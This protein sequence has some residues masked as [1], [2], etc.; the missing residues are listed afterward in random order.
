MANT[1]CACKSHNHALA[2]YVVHYIY[3]RSRCMEKS[4][5]D[6]DASRP[7]TAS[8]VNT[9]FY[10]NQMHIP[11]AYGTTDGVIIYS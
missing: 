5:A 4:V 6:N 1:K 8:R 3:K 9:I 11:S 2:A 7:S 10:A